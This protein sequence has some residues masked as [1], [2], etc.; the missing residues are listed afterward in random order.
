MNARGTLVE[1]NDDVRQYAKSALEELGLVA[2]DSAPAYCELSMMARIPIFCSPLLCGGMNGR[3]LSHEVLKARPGLAVLF[4]T[5]Y[6]P[7]PSFITAGS[8]RTFSSFP[9]PYTPDD[10]GRKRLGTQKTWQ[11][12]RLGNADAKDRH[13]KFATRSSADERVGHPL[14]TLYPC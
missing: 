7:N 4:T 2:H 6:T 9:K 10:L 8:I 14:V 1:D 3:R 12:K 5:G 11:R 13:A